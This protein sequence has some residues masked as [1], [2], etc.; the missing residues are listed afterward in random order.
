[1]LKLIALV[2]FTAP[3]A[4]QTTWHVDVHAPAGGNGSASAPFNSI[5]QAHDQSATFA[6]D[7][8]LVA[9]GTYDEHLTITKHLNVHSS[10]GALVTLIAP[11]SA[12][13]VVQLPSYSVLI[14]GGAWLKGLT[15]IHPPGSGGDT[16][17]ARSGLIDRCAIYAEGANNAVLVQYDLFLAHSLVTGA[18]VGVRELAQSGAFAWLYDSIVVGNTTDLITPVTFN[19]LSQY[20]CYETTQF[21]GDNT[22]VVASAQLFDLLGRD[23]HLS[24]T[25]PCI[26]AGDPLA[27]LDPDGTRADIGPFPFDPS[28]SPSQVYCTAQ[29]NSLGCTPAVSALGTASATSTQACTVSCVDE[30][31]QKTGLF[32]YGFDPRNTPYQGGYLCVASPLRRT[33]PMNSGGNVGLGDCSG[34]YSLDLNALIRSG[35]DPLLVPGEDVH[36]QCWSRDPGASSTTHRSDAVRLRILP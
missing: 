7:T 34:S 19:S 6:G 26:D 31:N 12:G 23:P 25:S 11:S 24:A 15:I 5:Q 13:T 30:L 17:T 16:I 8:I 10:G 2:L 29:V 22:N 14:G 20:C 21:D 1:M 35:S 18:Q 36:V 4:A 3:V 9:P 32:F 27:P 28:W 33:A